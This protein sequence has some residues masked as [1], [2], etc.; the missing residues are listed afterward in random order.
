MAPEA[1]G[2]GSE[3]AFVKAM[4]D[5]AHDL[6]LDDT[7]YANPVGLDAPGGYSSARGRCGRLKWMLSWR[8]N[9]VAGPSVPIPSCT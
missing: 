3:G 6:G 1:F 4:N 9:C 2:P 7:S 8:S 5:R